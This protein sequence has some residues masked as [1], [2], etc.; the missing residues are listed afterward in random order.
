MLAMIRQVRSHLGQSF[1]A[2]LSEKYNE[3]LNLKSSWRDRME[4]NR[5]EGIAFEKKIKLSMLSKSKV[6]EA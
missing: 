5:H 2:G 6:L 4:S 1:G 3:R